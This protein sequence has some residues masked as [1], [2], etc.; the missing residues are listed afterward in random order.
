MNKTTF[1]IRGIGQR[2]IRYNIRIPLK[3]GKGGYVD[4]GGTCVIN[5]V[6]E[7]PTEGEVMPEPKQDET[8]TSNEGQDQENEI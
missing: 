8:N 6:V 2:Y 5:E 7:I 4:V 1:T 3:S